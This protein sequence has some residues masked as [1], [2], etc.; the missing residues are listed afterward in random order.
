MLHCFQSDR[1]YNE[2]MTT[3]TVTTNGLSKQDSNYLQRIDRCLGDIKSIRQEIVR[4]RSEGRRVKA[5][6]DRNLKEIQTV[7]D[8]VEATF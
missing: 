8:R 5:R 4:K 1:D 6:I 7:I 2:I 3:R